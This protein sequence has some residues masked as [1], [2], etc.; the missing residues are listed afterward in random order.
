MVTDP[1]LIFHVS[2]DAPLS[3]TRNEFFMAELALNDQFTRVMAGH[4]QC[5]IVHTHRLDNISELYSSSNVLPLFTFL[6]RVLKFD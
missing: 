6:L 4:Q 1:T 3:R 2:V 5:H